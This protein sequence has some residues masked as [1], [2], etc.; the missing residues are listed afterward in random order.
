MI[1]WEPGIESAPGQNHGGKSE[2]L[3]PRRLLWAGL[4]SGVGVGVRPSDEQLGGRGRGTGGQ[5]N[6]LA[7]R[8]H[9]PRSFPE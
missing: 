2:V 5:R 7:E 9:T 1:S 3:W 4:P 8:A 6:R